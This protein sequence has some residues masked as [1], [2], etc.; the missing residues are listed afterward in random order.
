MYFQTKF[1]Q[2]FMIGKL[3]YSTKY[4]N[5]AYYSVNL[6]PQN[7]DKKRLPPKRTQFQTHS[8]L[9]QTLTCAVWIE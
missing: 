9:I 4:S 5:K 6:M 8:I 3:G 2:E 1:M 7:R